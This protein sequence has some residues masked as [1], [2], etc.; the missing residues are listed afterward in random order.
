MRDAAT[1]ASQPRALE[2]ASPGGFADWVR[3]CFGRAGPA[4]EV[5]ALPEIRLGH[6][7][8]IT[9]R[10]AYG[11][12][13]VTNVSVTLVGSEVARERISARTGISTVTD[14]HQFATLAVDRKMPDRTARAAEGRGAV[15]VPA[16]S[17]PSLAGKLNEI[18]W[19]IVVEAAY[20]ARPIWRGE[21]PVVVLPRSP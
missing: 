8:E 2:P 9:W 3:R 6:K 4:A 17:V 5:V 16:E 13:E 14:K 15:V 18:A 21:F 12:R 1:V 11:A 20:Q 19:A 10:L 7:L